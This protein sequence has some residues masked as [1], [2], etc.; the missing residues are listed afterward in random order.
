MAQP[1]HASSNIITPVFKQEIVL[2]KSAAAQ[3]TAITSSVQQGLAYLGYDGSF[4]MTAGSI[5]QA[6]EG[7]HPNTEEIKVYLSAVLEANPSKIIWQLG[8][9]FDPIHGTLVMHKKGVEYTLRLAPGDRIPS[10]S[11]RWQVAVR[12]SRNRDQA[13]PPGDSEAAQGTWPILGSNEPSVPAGNNNANLRPGGQREASGEAEDDSARYESGLRPNGDE[14]RGTL[15]AQNPTSQDWP[16]NGTT[17]RV[18]TVSTIDVADPETPNPRENVRY[19][20]ESDIIYRVS[21]K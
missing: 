10:H 3:I 7:L 14:Q 17:L 20:L 5:A 16:Q 12:A 18:V 15:S 2:T 1:V 9:L 4:V 6:Q 13:S 21:T 11:K 8:S 19:L